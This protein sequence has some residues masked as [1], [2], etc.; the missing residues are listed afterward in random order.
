MKKRSSQKSSRSYIPPAT[1]AATHPVR[2]QILK[3][4]KDGDKSTVELEAVTGE[5][6]YNLYHHLNELEK[7]GFI[8]W[9]MKDSKTKLFHL[10]TRKKPKEEFIILDEKDIRE[11]PEEVKV[12]MQALSKIQRLD[13]VE[14]DSLSDVEICLH[15]SR[16]KKKKK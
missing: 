6:R 5:A 3:T 14:L 2:A 13:S 16:D 9:T 8:S 1:K 12:L 4:L 7:A 11:K 10:R 15:F